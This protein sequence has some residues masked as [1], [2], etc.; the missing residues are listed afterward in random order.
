MGTL[1]AC[2]R[3]GSWLWGESRVLDGVYGRV[4]WRVKQREASEASAKA[5]GEKV[6]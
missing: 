2:S 6:R 3:S 4:L 1:R 5:R